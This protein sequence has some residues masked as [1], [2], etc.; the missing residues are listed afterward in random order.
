MIFKKKKR[1]DKKKIVFIAI[2]IQI[3]DSFELI[4][5]TDVPSMFVIHR[6]HCNIQWKYVLSVFPLMD[7]SLAKRGIIIS[8]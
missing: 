5:T 2:Y 6:N 1:K 7:E 8:K 3:G 4:R